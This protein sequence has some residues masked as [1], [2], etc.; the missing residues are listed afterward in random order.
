MKPKENDS[1]MGIPFEQLLAQISSRGVIADSAIPRRRVIDFWSSWERGKVI[2][3]IVGIVKPMEL[4]YR[5]E[6]GWWWRGVTDDTIDF[7]ERLTRVPNDTVSKAIF[8]FRPKEPKLDVVLIDRS[9][10][11]PVSLYT[12]RPYLTDSS[13]EEHARFVS[14]GRLVA[15]HVFPEKMAWRLSDQEVLAQMNGGDMTQYIA[16]LTGLI[17]PDPSHGIRRLTPAPGS[18]FEVLNQISHQG[19][20]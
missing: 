14:D 15:V 16:T 11:E 5:R 2:K 8:G 4:D 13:L 7:F 9:R 10:K 17:V 18:M 12:Y 6:E 20:S 1:P 19:A 3:D